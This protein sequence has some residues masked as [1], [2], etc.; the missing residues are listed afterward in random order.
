MKETAT[1]STTEKFSAQET[2]KLNALSE[3]VNNEKI[4][5]TTSADEKL[6]QRLNGQKS[7]ESSAQLKEDGNVNS[8]EQGEYGMM[9]CSD[10]CIKSRVSSGRC[11]HS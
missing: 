5:S 10:R 2:D 8:G 11:F 1:E 6:L 7:V 4:A 3:T 9:L